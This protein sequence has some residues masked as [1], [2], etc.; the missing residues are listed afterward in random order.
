MAL[1]DVPNYQS[2]HFQ[3]ERTTVQSIEWR[4]WPLACVLDV[5]PGGRWLRSVRNASYGPGCMEGG[6]L[7]T[8]LAVQG[9][10]AG[11]ALALR[12]SHPAVVGMA[13]LLPDPRWQGHVRLLDLFVHSQFE[14]DTAAL[15]DA[16][17]LSGGKVQCYVEPAE[18]ALLDTLQ[19]F[20]FAQEALLRGQLERDGKHV[21]V[22]VMSK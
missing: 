6:F 8:L 14:R 15:L 16:F 18:Q 21:D 10:R 13:T 3:P 4:D 2:A 22:L 19:H 11:Q 1:S 9:E 12:S 20:G 5:T 7:H 17:D